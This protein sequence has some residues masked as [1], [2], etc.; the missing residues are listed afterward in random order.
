MAEQFVLASI[1]SILILFLNLDSSP[2]LLGDDHSCC[3]HPDSVLLNSGQALSSQAGDSCFLP[4]TFCA[5]PGVSL[6]SA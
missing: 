5:T 3:L 2:F 4:V 6:V 1:I